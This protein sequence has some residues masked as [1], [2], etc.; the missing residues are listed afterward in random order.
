M[1]DVPG[2]GLAKTERPL[3][4][5]K[6]KQ[7]SFNGSNLPPASGFVTIPVVMSIVAFV[8]VEIALFIA[9]SI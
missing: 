4:L 7:I 6:V 8:A 5:S 3:T 1:V 2:D 9:V